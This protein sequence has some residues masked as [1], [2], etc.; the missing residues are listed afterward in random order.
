MSFNFFRGL[1]ATAVVALLVGYGVSRSV[2]NSSAEFDELT[3]ANIEALA[4]GEIFNG[5]FNGQYWTS[6]PNYGDAFLLS[7]FN[8][9]GNFCPKKKSCSINSGGYTVRASY[10]NKTTGVTV[11]AEYHSSTSTYSG[12]KITCIQGFGNCWNG[13]G[14]ID[15]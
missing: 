3:L 5:Y 2:N 12:E 11:K 4:E 9:I 14:C 10:K 6:N 1:I 13:T 15:S 8:Y 7:Q